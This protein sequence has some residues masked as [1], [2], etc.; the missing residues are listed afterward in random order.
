MSTIAE[1]RSRFRA[2]HESGCFVLP[3]PWDIGTARMMQQIGFHAIAT[4]S[5]GLAWSIGRPQ[6][7]VTFDDVV[8]HVASLCEKVDLPVSADFESGFACDPDGV[9]ANV[10]VVVDTGAAGFSI[11][12]RDPRIAS[13][14]FELQHAADRIRAAR[15][16]IDHFREEIVLVAQ[17]DR[18]MIDPAAIRQA[19]HRMEVYAD[20]GADCLC[21]PGLKSRQDIAAMVRAVAPKPL[22]VLI[23]EPGLSVAELA[24]LG[25]RRV[26]VGGRLAQ[27]A[28]DALIFAVHEMRNNSF[29]GLRCD[30]PASVIDAAFFNFL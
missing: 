27:I 12:D 9:G 16:T 2:L 15:E 18:L 7:K 28:M 8:E 17:T 23:V 1:K 5:A 25:V 10:D 19:M 14:L 30:T 26:S 3:S 22:S 11:Q 29:G 6:Y 24:D 4:T 20:A 21:V 13:G